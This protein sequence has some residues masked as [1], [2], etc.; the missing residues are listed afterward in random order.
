MRCT[1][2]LLLVI[3]ACYSQLFAYED[4]VEETEEP[5]IM[6]CSVPTKIL[7]VV[8]KFER[9]AKRPIGYQYII[10]F[11]NQDEAKRAKEA[12]GKD[13]FLDWRTIDCKNENLCMKILS[14]VSQE[15]NI[16]NMDLGSFQI[17]YHHHKMPIRDYFSFE[18]SYIKACN[19]L[20]TLIANYGYSWQTIA[21][22]NHKNPKV[23]QPY[24]EK[25]T[26]FMGAEQ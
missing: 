10:A 25:I 13:L 6:V 18:K 16:D 1:I 17:N 7:E 3:L 4:I 15:L 11:N 23:N 21:K 2:T 8:A 19:Y 9:H 22:Y 12:I 20:E 14:Y 26:M 5:Q 24:L